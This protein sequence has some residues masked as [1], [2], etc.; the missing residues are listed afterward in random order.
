MAFY[1][2][3]VCRR[4][5]CKFSGFTWFAIVFCQALAEALKVNKTLTNINLSLNNIDKEGA[6]AWC[7]G[8]RVCGSRP[9]NGCWTLVEPADFLEN[10]RVIGFG[11]FANPRLAVLSWYRLYNF[12]GLWLTKRCASERFSAHVAGGKCTFFHRFGLCKHCTFCILLQVLIFPHANVQEMHLP[13]AHA[14]PLRPR[15]ALGISYNHGTNLENVCWEC[16]Q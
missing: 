16:T 8:R 5:P 14:T 3:L 2:L 4:S 12:I 1:F 6:K 7:L 11:S 10:W 15:T 13:F 9:R